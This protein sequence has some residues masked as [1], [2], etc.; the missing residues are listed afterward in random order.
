MR[1]IV[2]MF[3][4]F[5]SGIPSLFSQDADPL[6][7]IKFTGFVKTDFFYDTRQSSASNGLREG[8]FY[9]FPDNVL[10]DLEG[11]DINA[12]PAFHILG[13][14]TRIKGDITGPDAFGAKTS[15]VIESEFFGT[16]EADLNGFRLRHAYV[17]LD[18]AKTIL[19]IGQSWHPMFPAESFPGTVSFNTGAPFVPFSRNPQVRLTRKAGEASFSLTA[20]SQRDFTSPG[21]DGNSSKYLRNSGI[22]GLNILLKVPAGDYITTWAGFDYKTLRPELRSSLNAETETEIGSFSTFANIRLNTDPVTLSVMGVYCQNASDLMMIGG[23]AVS[24]IS[25][26]YEEYKTYTNMTTASI[27]ADLS[28]KGKKVLFGIFTG[29]TKNLGSGEMITGSVYGRGNNI[30][31]IFRIS[32]RI[33]ITEGR[34]SFAAEIE[35]TVAAY[36]T[37]QNNGR[38]TNTNNVSNLRILL[39]SVYKF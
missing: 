20:Y 15:G 7:G 33:T 35:N 14:Q 24:D 18:W 8:H 34:L 10:Y 23:Y 3:F 11:N 2:V 25:G 9:L 37:M 16:S 31:N 4:C 5:I 1:R 39:S 36:G 28:T 29:F 12:N 21:P 17:K 38:V 26:L 30:D 32:P 13:I 6:W 19:L 27:W 22:P